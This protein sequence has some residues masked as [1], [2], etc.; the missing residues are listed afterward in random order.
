MWLYFP[1]LFLINYE[2]IF[3]L[4]YFILLFI[5]VIFLLF[6]FSRRQT[7]S[8]GHTYTNPRPGQYL[9]HA[10]SSS[11]HH[12]GLWYTG[13]FPRS[14]TR[15]LCH[16]V[17]PNI[18]R[19]RQLSMAATARVIWPGACVRYWPGRGLVYVCPLPYVCLIL[20]SLFLGRTEACK[21][22]LS[23]FLN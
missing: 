11:A 12:H 23:L 5:F 13:L 18:K 9:T 8:K 17:S 14:L 2:H 21:A 16:A 20:F 15:R 3:I 4:F 19:A 7:W 10:H 1:P 22:E 6:F